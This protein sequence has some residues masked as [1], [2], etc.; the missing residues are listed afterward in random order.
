MARRAA[1]HATVIGRIEDQQRDTVNGDV[2]TIID[3]VSMHPA[4]SALQSFASPW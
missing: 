1:R 4:V 2:Y 3:H